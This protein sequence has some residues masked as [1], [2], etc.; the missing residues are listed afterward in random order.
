MWAPGRHFLCRLELFADLLQVLAAEHHLDLRP[1]DVLLV[2]DVLA[3]R[4]DELLQGLVVVRLAGL[5][6]LEPLQQLLAGLL[7]LKRF[8][9]ER[10]TNRFAHRRPEKLLLDGFVLRLGDD[11]VV[12]HGLQAADLGA[13]ARGCA[14]E[15]FQQSEH[16]F[17]VLAKE[18]Y[19]VHTLPS[20]WAASGRIACGYPGVSP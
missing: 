13:R 19:C 1:H 2:G 10:V 5:S 9:C 7:L 15:R 6:V 16:A 17:V 3:A 14:V 18:S 4:F 20:D 12:H 8:V 11:E